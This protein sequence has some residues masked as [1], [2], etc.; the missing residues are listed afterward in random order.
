MKWNFLRISSDVTSK[1]V[2]RKL[3]KTYTADGRIMEDAIMSVEDAQ[4]NRM[5]YIEPDKTADK[6]AEK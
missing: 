2:F 5:K 4:D 6:E 1:Y 3:A